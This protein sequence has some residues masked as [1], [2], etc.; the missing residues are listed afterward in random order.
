MIAPS[1]LAASIGREVA[2]KWYYVTIV[3]AVYCVVGM[4]ALSFISETRD[5][6]IEASPLA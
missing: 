4:L 2:G 3:Y 5:V 1:L 6:D